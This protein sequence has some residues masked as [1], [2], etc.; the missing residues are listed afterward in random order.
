MVNYKQ[1]FEV[2]SENYVL[3]PLEIFA[4][5][6]YKTLV[7]TLMSSRTNDETTLEA[8]KRLFAF[9]PDI[10]AL[11]KLSTK[12]IEKL[13]FPVGFYKTKSRQLKALAQ[14]VLTDY[15]GAIPSDREELMKL[16]GV[17]RKT[18][19][20]VLNRAFGKPAI[21]VDTHVH[22]ITNLLNWVKSRKPEET[23]QR[24]MEVIPQKYWYELN[25]LFV[26]IGRQY[27]S[28][29]QLRVFLTENKLI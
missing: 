28:E 17:G 23:E 1:V 19:N 24:L 8:A 5:D 12:Q 15:R 10:E 26:S 21:A 3:V 11:E 27:R 22:R 2:F 13:I 18:A 29:R 9:A 20:L 16:P 25:R 7:S 14:K 4:E 6:P